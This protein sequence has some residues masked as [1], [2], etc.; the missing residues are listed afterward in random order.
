MSGEATVIVIMWVF[1][2]LLG[3]KLCF[4][5]RKE[6]EHEKGR[7]EKA[8]KINASLLKVNNNFY[9]LNKKII[10]ENRG[11]VFVAENIVKGKPGRSLFQAQGMLRA[12]LR[13]QMEE[14]K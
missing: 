9:K 10:S 3:A 5:A 14:K 1:W 7:V 11:L 6:L 8:R 12:A 13:T 4:K 2:L